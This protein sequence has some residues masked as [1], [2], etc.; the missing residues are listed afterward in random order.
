MSE[1]ESFEQAYKFL[2]EAVPKTSSTIFKGKDGFIKSKHWMQEL[3]NPQDTSS[4]IHIAGTS[5]KGTVAHLISAIFEEHGKKTVLITSPHAYDIRERIL[6]GGK[7]LSKDNFVRLINQ[8]M[9]SYLKMK[10]S[11]SPPSYFEMLMAMGF[12]TAANKK[13][14]YCVVETGMGGR[15]DT[16]NTINRK[17]K[18]CVIT[19]IGYD[20]THILGNTLTEIATQ[21]VGIAH[22][23]QHVLSAQQA[24]EA[25]EAIQ[26]GCDQVGAFLTVVDPKSTLSRY[27]LDIHLSELNP[28]LPGDHSRSNLALALESTAYVAKRDGWEID[29][30]LVESAIRKFKVPGRFEIVQGMGNKEFIFDGAHNE[31]KMNAL[32]RALEER[33]GKRPLGFVFASSKEEPGKHLDILKG[34]AGIV[35]LTRYHSKELDTLRP[36]PNLE[37][38]ANGKSILYMPNAKDVISY[39]KSSDLPVWVITGSFYILGEIKNLLE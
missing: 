8:I 9:P 4:T 29:A 36:Q 23:K 39:I 2:V 6:I 5:G 18:L 7:K 15:L 32:V 25:M 37:I 11:G 12:V 22:H 21:K 19:P 16:S 1:I 31:Q 28:Q 13:V 27:G 24:P 10:E 33:Y 20:H 14:N 34:K 38:L 30:T 26:A 3:G 17:D 35:I